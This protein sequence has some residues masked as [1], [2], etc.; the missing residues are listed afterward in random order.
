MRGK[1]TSFLFIAVHNQGAHRVSICLWIPCYFKCIIT[2]ASN[3]HHAALQL[4]KNSN[5]PT[6]QV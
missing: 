5:G 3:Y 6:T 4:V 2:R 1:N